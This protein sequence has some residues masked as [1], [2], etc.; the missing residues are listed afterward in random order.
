MSKG[1]DGRAPSCLTCEPAR[2]CSDGATS[3][4]LMYDHERGSPNR[5]AGH[6]HFR[7]HAKPGSVQTLE[8]KNL[9]NIYNGRPGSVANEL[10]TAVVSSDGSKWQPI[11]LERLPGDRVRLTLTMPGSALYVARTEP[12]RLSDLAK[13]LAKIEQD[14]RVEITQI[15]KTAEGRPLEIVRIGRPE[16]PYRVFLRARAHAW[17][18]GGNW[19]VQGLANRLLQDDVEAKKYLATYCVYV[20][21]MANKDAVARGRT[22]FNSRGK[23]LNRDWNRPADPE[24]A[25]E[26]HALESWLEKMIKRGRPLTWR[27]NSIM[28]GTASCTSADRRYRAWSA[29]SIV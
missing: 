11:P 18:A 3:I 23:D 7:L 27:W 19:V 16:A 20:M 15:G 9:E 14:P 28:T 24:L 12:Y 25:P 26:N 10:K 5:A 4:Y 22:R 17:E 2:A 21:P 8:F 13:W 29:M 6:F 1:A